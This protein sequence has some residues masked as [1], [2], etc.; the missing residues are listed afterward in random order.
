MGRCCFDAVVKFALIALAE[1]GGAVRLWL[2]HEYP[3]FKSNE[4]FQN[5]H[6][7]A[8]ALTPELSDEKAE[9]VEKNPRRMSASDNLMEHVQTHLL[10]TCCCPMTPRRRLVRPFR[11]TLLFDPHPRVRNVPVLML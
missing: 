11:P 6:D 4:L 3:A 5:D 7:L 10:P 2:R 8:K 1:R 9:P